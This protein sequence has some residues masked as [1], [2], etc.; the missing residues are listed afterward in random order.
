MRLLTC[1][2]GPLRAGEAVGLQPAFARSSASC[3]TLISQPQ[4]PLQPPAE[5]QAVNGVP[6]A[7][8]PGPMAALR[9][10]GAAPAAEAAEPAAAALEAAA[11]AAS[12]GA[13]AAAHDAAVAATAGGAPRRRPARQRAR[14]VLPRELVPEHYQDPHILG[15]CVAVASPMLPPIPHQLLTSRLTHTRPPGYHARSQTLAL[16]CACPCAAASQPAWR[17][18]SRTQPPAYR[19]HGWAHC[20]LRRRPL[21]RRYRPPGGF[22]KNLGSL[23]RL[24]NETGNVWSHLVRLLLSVLLFRWSRD[25]PPTSFQQAGLMGKEAAAHPSSQRCPLCNADWVHHLCLPH[26]CHRAPEARAAGV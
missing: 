18:P 20:R 16:G 3:L 12:P 6:A 14:A 2:L 8:A 9:R 10:R 26:G 22:R 4:P 13:A 5:A 1:R 21:L 24:H 19:L 17:R 25:S 11:G 23:F 15:W 7:P